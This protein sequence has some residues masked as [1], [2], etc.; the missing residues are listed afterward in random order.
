MKK[1]PLTKIGLSSCFMYPDKNRVSYPQKTL[2]YMEWDLVQYLSRTGV[3]P[4]LIPDVKEPLLSQ[5]MQELDGIVLH[6]GVDMAP[7]SYGEGPIDQERWPGD[8]RRDQYELLLLKLAFSLNKPILGIC[9]GCQVLNVFFGGTLFQ[10]ILTQREGSLIHRDADVYDRLSHEISIL[11]GG[12]L[13]SLYQGQE[14]LPNRVNTVHHQGIKVL[15]KNLQV[16][17][18]CPVDQMIEGISY[19]HKED[20]FILGVQW[21]PEYS[22]ALP[23][24]VLPEQ[25]I[26]DLFLKECIKRRA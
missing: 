22:H 18:V 24:E 3:L 8:P 19:Q 15:G 10:D 21:H 9:R 6:G 26:F 13:H 1:G 20:K 14:T 23:G 12:H 16:E 17:A 11:P 25:P 2:Q 7:Q 5:Y 4:V